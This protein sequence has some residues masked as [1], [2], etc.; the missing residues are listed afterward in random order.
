MELE[1][2]SSI[3]DYLIIKKLKRNTEA[4]S[5]KLSER[6]DEGSIRFRNWA[7][8]FRLKDKMKLYDGVFKLRNQKTSSNIVNSS[9]EDEQFFEM[10]DNLMVSTAS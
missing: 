5:Q 1:K 2:Y 7:T 6:P 9:L 10:T 4:I 8:D 3:A